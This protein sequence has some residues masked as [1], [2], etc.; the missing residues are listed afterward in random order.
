MNAPQRAAL[1]VALLSAAITATF[2]RLAPDAFP[3]AW[4]AAL[5][6]W[7][8][9]PLGS[10]ALLLIH[11]LTGD[12]W[13]DALRTELAA[14]VRSLLLLPLLAIPFLLTATSLYPWLNAHGLPNAFYLNATFALGRLILYFVVWF[15]LGRLIL[16]TLRRVSSLVSIAPGGLVALALTTTFM[17]IDAIMSL[18]P[19]FASSVFGLLRMAEMALFALSAAILAASKRGIAGAPL[20]QNG[21]LLLALAIL[22]AY[23]DFMQLL[24]VWQSN[25]PNEA[26]WYGPRLTG[27]WGALAAAVALTHFALPF[28]A[29][30]ST[31]VQTSRACMAS[32]T[33]LL[34]LAAC[35]RSLWLVG[36]EARA[37]P[38]ILVA[39]FVAAVVSMFAASACMTLEAPISKQREPVRYEREN[40]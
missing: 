34:M 17:S 5:A 11:A 37:D 13:G 15:A 3:Y 26:A 2:W 4:L 21:R 10:M 30:L 28:F 38:P 22:W 9:L 14:G 18:D 8:G 16:S 35:A 36:P 19:R 23:L 40:A 1:G 20:R 12:A 25:L 31:R 6:V 24:I 27:G 33:A 32:L 7:I 29:L 39:T